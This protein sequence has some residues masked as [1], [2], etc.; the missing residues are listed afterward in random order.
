LVLAVEGGKTLRI[1]WNVGPDRHPGD[2][3]RDGLFGT[4]ITLI[5][6]VAPNPSRYF[7]LPPYSFAEAAADLHG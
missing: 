1:A 3:G 6:S 4:G 2:P 5:T 7:A